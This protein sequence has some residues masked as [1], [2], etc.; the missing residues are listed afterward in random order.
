MAIRLEA[1]FQELLKLFND[2][3]VR[4]LLIGGYA[5]ILNGYVRN[6]T[7][8]DLAVAA[9]ADNAERM[10][11]ALREFG[12]REGVDTSLFTKPRSL[13]RFG[14]EPLK[15]EIINYLEGLDFDIAYERRNVA[16]LDGLTISLIHIDDLIAN[17]TAV[18]RHIDLADV[19]ELK[20]INDK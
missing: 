12:F 5:V 11:K 1:D 14:F 17:K 16:E 4:Y 13:V 9:D 2:N 18:G 7:D 6:T 10:V 20:K 19:E 15:V 3:N 8:M